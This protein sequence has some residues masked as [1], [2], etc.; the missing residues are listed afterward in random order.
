M[1]VD[2]VNYDDNGKKKL[3][4]GKSANIKKQDQRKA[5]NAKGKGNK[6]KTVVGTK[7]VKGK[8]DPPKAVY[9]YEY[10]LTKGEQDMAKMLASLLSVSDVPGK[11]L[12]HPLV[13][14]GLKQLKLANRS[15]R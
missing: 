12:K 2:L 5:T 11:L 8:D 10:L 15:R 1:I 14:D 9:T 3:M 13:Q 7:S 4:A 6:G